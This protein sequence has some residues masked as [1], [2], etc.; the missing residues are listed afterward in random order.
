[1]EKSQSASRN[2]ETKAYLHDFQVG[3]GTLLK[4][5][6]E[7]IQ[8]WLFTKN[9]STFCQCTET[10]C[11]K[12]NTLISLAKKPAQC[13]HRSTWSTAFRQVCSKNTEQEPEQESWKSAVWQE[14]NTW[15]SRPWVCLWKPSVPF[16]TNRTFYNTMSKN[17]LKASMGFIITKPSKSLGHK[18][19]NSLES[20]FI[21]K[22]SKPLEYLAHTCGLQSARL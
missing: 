20:Y 7:V 15:S 12:G 19:V 17:V 4:G 6:L 13:S 22:K 2:A 14:R 8:I 3:T 21:E 9:L 5:G 18:T 10:W 1:M 16:K 11:V